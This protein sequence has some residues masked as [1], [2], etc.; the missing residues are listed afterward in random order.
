[1]LFV[2]LP[3]SLA[4]LAA[5][6]YAAR[7]A[8][9][10]VRWVAFVCWG[11]GLSAGPAGLGLIPTVTGLQ[12]AWLTLA[13]ATWAF[14]RHRLRS[15]LPLA[16]LAFVA[17]YLT[18]GLLS[19]PALSD[20]ARMQERFPYE[21]MEDRVPPPKPDDRH[22][23]L[24]KSAALHLLVQDERVE[25][26]VHLDGLRT[27]S[28]EDIHER[29]TRLFVNSPGFGVA[30]LR[31]P[32]EG[33]L[34]PMQRKEPP[35][36]PDAGRTGGRDVGVGPRLIG[37]PAASLDLFELHTDGVLDFVNPGGFGFVKDRRRVAGFQP[38]G[39]H[40]VPGPA[41]E[42]EVMTIHL[43]SLL[44]HPE[45]AVY[46]SPHLPAMDQ[47]RELPTR[48]LDEF[49]AA[50]LKAL[51]GGQDLEAAEAGERLHMLGSLRNGRRCLGCHGGEHGDLLGAFSYV[52]RT[53]GRNP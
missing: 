36:H 43:V 11:L 14:L 40:R 13:L 3:L 23:P 4:V 21:S 25:Q 18:G 48:P 24:S 47:A 15:F 35:E 34:A 1:M 37:S 33:K 17:A 52:L 5:A 9:Q 31:L 41:L 42:W 44:L 22:L 7:P 10:P 16:G 20:Y 28:L 32:T 39:F 49:E 6:W 19:L 8:P 38:H 51:R 27:E 53:R 2:S 46:L 29:M 26:D 50:G 12:F 30:R 45:P